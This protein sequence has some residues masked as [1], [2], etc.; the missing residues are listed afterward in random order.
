MLSDGG[1]SIILGR[2]L[3]FIFPLEIENGVLFELLNINTAA[4]THLAVVHWRNK[5]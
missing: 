5:A 2:D 3:Y 4:C 1:L